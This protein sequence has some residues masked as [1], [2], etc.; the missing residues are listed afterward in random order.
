MSV[1]WRPPEDSDA[2]KVE[3]YVLQH[4]EFK[5]TVYTNASFPATKDKDTYSFR[6]QNLEPETIYMI[7]VGARNKYGSNYNEEKS[8]ETLDAPFA[9]WIIAVIVL[10]IVLVLG[11]IVGVIIC[12]RKRAEERRRKL[13]EEEGPRFGGLV[14]DVR[15]VRH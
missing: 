2:F 12:M 5:A 11:I 3:E 1:R 8:H 6:I 7:R 4:R 9:K 13:E 10:A 15:M 14:G